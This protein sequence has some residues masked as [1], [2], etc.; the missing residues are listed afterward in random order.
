MNSFFFVVPDR[1]DPEADE[2]YGQPTLIYNEKKELLCTTMGDSMYQIVASIA[3]TLNIDEKGIED[4][5]FYVDTPEDL[6]AEIAYVLSEH[7][8]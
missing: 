7:V 1:D 8:A 6:D 4:R 2:R 5:V 3:V